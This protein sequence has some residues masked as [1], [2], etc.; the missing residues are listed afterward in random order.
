MEGF[1]TSSSTPEPIKPPGASESAN[2]LAAS[3][4]STLTGSFYH[5]SSV[6]LKSR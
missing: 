1:R 6:F 3:C 4:A 5:L 2:Q